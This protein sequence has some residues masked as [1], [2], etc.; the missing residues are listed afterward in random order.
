MKHDQLTIVS[1]YG[2]NDGSGALPSITH[3]MK[4]LPG[5][6]GLL[7]SRAKPVGLPDNIEWKQV[8]IID[9]LQY[10]VFMMHCLQHHIKTDYCLVV[11]DDGW[12]LNGE[13]FKEKYYD[14]DYIG[15]PSHCGRVGD[16]FLLGFA[17]TK[18]RKRTVVQN[19][20]FSLR[21]KKF[22]QA[23]NEFGIV[24]KQANDIHNWNE[25]AQ[26]TAI[27]RKDLEFCG[28]KYA[29]EK[30]AKDFSIEYVGPKFH[31]G[32]DFKRLVGHH[33]QSR[34][35]IGENYVRITKPHGE[36]KDFHREL[37]FVNFLYDLGYVVE[38]DSSDEQKRA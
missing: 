14:Y 36:I 26:L 1:V 22:L 25:D 32:F 35:L 24:H 20:G 8:G 29:P 10:S 33:A 18:H 3:S 12:V 37:E 9:Y 2:H 13:N 5:S 21:S 23:C 34:R 4:Q 28:L 19:G 27:Y 17:W 6:K 31:D 30:I 7:L 15:A 11:Q 38:Y 16:Q